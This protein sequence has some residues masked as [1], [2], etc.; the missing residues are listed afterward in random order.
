[1]LQVNK[2]WQD[3]SAVFNLGCEALNLLWCKYVIFWCQCTACEA[4]LV[5]P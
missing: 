2:K 4:L 1:M 5:F 3:I